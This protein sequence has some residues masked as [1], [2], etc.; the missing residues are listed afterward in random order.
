V[1]VQYEY[2][3]SKEGTTER[4]WVA[5]KEKERERERVC[6]CVYEREREREKERES[7][8]AT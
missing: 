4:K 7:V 1:C 5:S 3:T 2:N 6:V 8:C